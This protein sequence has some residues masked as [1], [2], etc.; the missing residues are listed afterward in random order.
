MTST[1]ERYFKDC[2]SHVAAVLE[3]GDQE[4]AARVFEGMAAGILNWKDT[5]QKL[6]SGKSQIIESVKRVANMNVAWYLT[7][8]L[9][10]LQG[11]SSERWLWYKYTQDMW[12]NAL[13]LRL[14][15]GNNH[16]HFSLIKDKNGEEDAVVCLPR[17][18]PYNYIRRLELAAE[19]ILGSDDSVWDIQHNCHDDRLTHWW[20]NT[21]H[22]RDNRDEIDYSP[23]GDSE[24]NM[25]LFRGSE[26][27][28][29]TKKRNIDTSC[30][31]QFTARWYD[32]THQLTRS[33]CNEALTANDEKYKI[34]EKSLTRRLLGDEYEFRLL[35]G[36]QGPNYRSDVR[37]SN[38]Q[39]FIMCFDTNTPTDWD[40]RH[41]VFTVTTMFDKVMTRRRCKYKTYRG[42]KRDVRLFYTGLT[43][44]RDGS[45]WIHNDDHEGY[46]GNCWPTLLEE[47][48][49]LEA[50]PRKTR[51]VSNVTQSTQSMSHK[52]IVEAFAKAEKEG[53]IQVN[54]YYGNFVGQQNATANWTATQAALQSDLDSGYIQNALAFGEPLPRC[55]TGPCE[56]MEAIAPYLPYVAG[57]VGTV[58]TVF[59]AKKVWERFKSRPNKDYKPVSGEETTAV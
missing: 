45:I 40:I 41:R 54:D 42:E 46:I 44:Q 28:N 59:T 7:G 29:Y 12:T 38:Y 52:E 53:L 56:Y 34:S 39:G 51:D 55:A 25:R 47:V 31:D 27:L 5:E 35:T 14:R 26:L 50:K 11:A 17:P 6:D 4:E 22:R 10:F 21:F 2:W 43:I 9:Q 24:W 19:Q 57:I 20:A 8:M 48:Q 37:N 32:A 15:P 18:T 23:H 49:G 36:F 13:C 33:I 58:G 1:F 3:G 16:V 30:R